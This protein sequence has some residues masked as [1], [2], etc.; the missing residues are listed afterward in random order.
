MNKQ[1]LELLNIYGSEAQA[2][3]Y[4][5]I[6]EQRSNGIS[7]DDIKSSLRTS[8]TTLLDKMHLL[9]KAYQDNN[10]FRPHIHPPEPLCYSLPSED[11]TEALQQIQ[12]AASMPYTEKVALMPD[13]H[14]GYGMPIGGV[15]R[16]KNAI[17]PGAVGVDIGCSVYATMLN[18][19][20]NNIPQ[21]EL[22]DMLIEATAFGQEKAPPL[23][24]FS[25]WLRT[26]RDDEIL[27]SYRDMAM[28]QLG[29]SGRGNHFVN[30]MVLDVTPE[31]AKAI[32]FWYHIK[33][34]RYIVIVSHSGSRKVGY[35]LA[36][37]Y[38][39]RALEQS[40]NE[41]P[42]E[43][44]YFA[45]LD[46]DSKIGKEYTYVMKSLMHYAHL[47][48]AAIHQNII[49]TITNVHPTFKLFTQHNYAERIGN[50]YIHRKGT[51]NASQYHTG[52][53]PGSMF[54]PVYIVEGLGNEH[55]LNSASHG[56]GRVSSRT[57][58]KKV[59]D[60]ALHKRLAEMTGV[61]QIGGEL[62]ESPLAYKSIKEVIE[63][64]EGK[65]I[66]TIAKLQPYIT[67]MH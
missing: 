34:Q 32:P 1:Q 48:H 47:N 14:P 57:Q 65:T 17:V 33:P 62:D 16:T 56:A 50:N 6:A 18:L 20:V 59:I 43:L 66:K 54:E 51:I 11:I 9:S 35:T 30:L 21:K 19:P 27:S 41:L 24:K 44:K 7:I 3:A 10:I 67:R 28:A 52:L 25:N 4:K 5:Y 42:K 12:D 23:R 15:M 60:P 13:A 2:L 53:I 22:G 64:Q 40:P 49:G 45:W 61:L 63:R 58:A 36:N 26:W 31:L 29:T 38:M 55:W 8:N 39:A 46:T 37:K